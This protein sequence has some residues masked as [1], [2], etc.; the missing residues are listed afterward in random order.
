NFIFKY[1]W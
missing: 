1:V